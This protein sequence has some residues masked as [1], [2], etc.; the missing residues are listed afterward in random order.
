MRINVGSGPNPV[1]G[2]KN[3]DNSL[4]VR[5]AKIPFIPDLLSV[6][7][8]LNEPQYELVRVARSHKIE[9]ADITRKLPISDGSVEVLYSSPGISQMTFSE[10]IAG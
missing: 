8:L 5:L 2:W 6:L 9:F 4:S 1:I 7:K 3:F 10:N